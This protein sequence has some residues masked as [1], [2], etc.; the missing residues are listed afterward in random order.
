M[1]GTGS[2]NSQRE[3]IQV[4]SE[5]SEGGQRVH[6]C[7][8]ACL[9]K[10]LPGRAAAACATAGSEWGTATM[11]SARP[12]SLDARDGK[13]SLSKLLLDAAFA[14][15][16]PRADGDEDLPW[17]IESGIDPVGPSTVALEQ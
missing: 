14:R 15:Q 13:A 1:G 12:T 9:R 6:S 2:T 10:W 7:P 8:D 17:R 16:V 4:I 5:G 11:L 3:V